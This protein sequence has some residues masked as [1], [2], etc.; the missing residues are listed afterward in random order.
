MTPRWV[1]TGRPPAP[2]PRVMVPSRPPRVLY[3]PRPQEAKGRAQRA[4]PWTGY[5]APAAYRQVA[6]VPL[7][8]YRR[9]WSRLAA[10]PG[11]DFSISTEELMAGGRLPDGETH[12]IAPGRGLRAEGFGGV[13]LCWRPFR[14]G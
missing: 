6:A 14:T 2:C 12:C 8:S 5:V 4:D 3:L 7:N 13:R 10:A 1:G 11:G 9:R